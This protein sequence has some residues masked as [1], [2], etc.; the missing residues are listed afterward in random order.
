MITLKE[1]K[2][3]NGLYSLPKYIHVN[4][5]ILLDH[6]LFYA[7]AEPDPKRDLVY[8]CD[9]YLNKYGINLQR[10]YVWEHYQQK[11]FIMSILTEK[12]MD[13]VIIV[14]HH[15]DSIEREHC[16]NY[17]I[18]GK[19]RLTTIKKFAHNEFPIQVNGKDYYF[20]D[21]D[22]E[23]RRFF[24]S[25]VN[26]IVATVYYS[27]DDTPITDDMKITLF[28]FYNFSGTPQTEEHK[29]N[30]INLMKKEDETGRN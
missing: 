17:V 2:K 20:K 27:Y 14:Q 16:V 18:D 12:E 28:N 3:L 9:V 30:L 22:D 6:R 11:E 13:P 15:K 1:I 24:I 7:L 26:Y 19:Q 4:K 29:N 23:L 5:H 10:A 21:F 25:R 8:D